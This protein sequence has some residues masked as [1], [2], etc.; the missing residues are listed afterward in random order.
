MDTAT[1][2]TTWITFREMLVAKER[3]YLDVYDT[4]ECL[5]GAVELSEVW[6]GAQRVIVQWMQRKMIGLSL[7]Q[8]RQHASQFDDECVGLLTQVMDTVLRPALE[9]GRLSRSLYNDWLIQLSTQIDLLFVSMVDAIN[10]N[11][12]R[13]CTFSLHPTDAPDPHTTGRT[14]FTVS[15]P[16]PTSA[17]PPTLAPTQD[18]KRRRRGGRGRGGASRERRRGRKGEQRREREPEQRRE[19]EPE[20]RRERERASIRRMQDVMRHPSRRSSTS[21]WDI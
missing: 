14:R 21:K 3:S 10:A 18:R 5:F 13:R 1:A 12:Q 20:Q 15:V 16:T 7:E 17:P 2:P 4:D 19:R 11:T 8:T 9:T 6:L